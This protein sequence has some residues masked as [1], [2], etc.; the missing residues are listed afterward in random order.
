MGTKSDCSLIFS[1]FRSGFVDLS[2][3]YDNL[4]SPCAIGNQKNAPNEDPKK[5]RY[6]Q[7]P[8]WKSISGRPDDR[9]K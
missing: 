3:Q 4:K 5:N 8:D 6:F 2:C 1:I 7:S 9:I